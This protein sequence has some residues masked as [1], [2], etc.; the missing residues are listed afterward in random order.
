MEAGRVI[1]AKEELDKR[2]AE[3]G[4]QISSDYEG[5]D[6]LLLGILK[7]SIVFLTELMRYITVPHQIDFITVSSYGVGARESSGLV[8][9]QAVPNITD[10]NVLIVE[11]IIDTGYTLDYLRRQLLKQNPASLRICCLLDKTERRKITVP[12]DYLGFPVP[13]VY[14]IGFG[15]DADEYFRN[16]PYVA[17]LEE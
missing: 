16:L 15:L 10:R 6:I 11:D 17:E 8:H 9:I 5:R 14:L 7:G 2:L 4:T 3:L 12:I 13:N 1:V